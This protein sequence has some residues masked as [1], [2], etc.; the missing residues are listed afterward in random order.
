MIGSVR[1]TVLER[2][3]TG[4]V[5]VE[6]G[7]V[8]YRVHRPDRRAR[9]SSIRASHAFLFTH[10]HV[11][12]DAMVLF[13][14][15]TR[16]ERDTFEALIAATGVGPKLAL[17]ILS[18]HTPERVAPRLADDDLDALVL[19]PGVG[20]RTAQRLLVELKARLE[21]PDLDLTEPTGEA[22]TRARAEVREALG[23]A[24]LLGRRGARRA[25]PDSPTTATGR[26]AAPRRAA[27]ARGPVSRA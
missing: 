18:V 11:R 21:V 5:L 16:D 4:E 1:G 19:V 13:G 27:R 10:L 17:A 14:F 12:E 3:P 20:K 7:G 15:P 9:R 25:R 26:R 6:V 2:T 24:R 22:T 8:G 23:R